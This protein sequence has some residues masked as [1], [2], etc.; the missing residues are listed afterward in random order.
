MSPNQRANGK[1]RAGALTTPP[2]TGGDGSVLLARVI[3]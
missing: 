1:R 3:P 2:Q